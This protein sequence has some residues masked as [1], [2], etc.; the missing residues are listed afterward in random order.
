MRLIG[1]EGIATRVNY[2]YGLNVADEYIK[3]SIADLN[4]MRIGSSGFDKGVER[5]FAKAINNMATATLGGN[6]S[7]VAKQFGSYALALKYIDP[8][9]L[10]AP[11]KL[12][13]PKQM[14]EQFKVYADK[15]PEI[16]L[17]TM[18]KIGIE[19]ADILASGKK[20]KELALKPI[21]Q[22][23]LITVGMLY[24]SVERQI[25]AT[26]PNLEVGSPQYW[27]EVRKLGLKVL[28][29]QP[30]YISSSRS[31][32]L[33]TKNPFIKGLTMFQTVPNT[34]LNMLDEG[35]DVWKTTGDAK[36]LIRSSIGVLQSI[37]YVSAV[38]LST[39]KLA[40]TLK[41]DYVTENDERVKETSAKEEVATEALRNTVGMFP[42]ASQVM[43]GLQGYDIQDIGVGKIN[44]IFRDVNSLVKLINDEPKDG[45]SELDFWKDVARKSAKLTTDITEIS[46]G[47][48]VK[49]V[50]KLGKQ[51]SNI[52]GNTKLKYQLDVSS[53]KNFT[54]TD[55][56]DIILHVQR[57]YHYKYH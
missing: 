13:N 30:E 41:D 56:Y 18:G 19:S 3:T 1:N 29:T 33:R 16:Q 5:T 57:A 2:A 14:I 21:K 47:L 49:N 8:K 51:L 32:L 40:R 4:N 28:E 44:S 17:R 27:G 54:A 22:M 31:A 36:P 23:D 45:T 42:F 50:P 34:M 11:G 25:K 7:V 43:S 39:R 10:Y 26:M 9:Y 37:A 46:T 35:I 6:F 24:D 12:L 48:P 15:F 55:I 52:T 53:G 38:G 20:L